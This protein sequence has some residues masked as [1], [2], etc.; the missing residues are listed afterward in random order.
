MPATPFVRRATLVFLVLVPT[1]GRSQPAPLA[2]TSPPPLLA[3]A[4]PPPLLAPAPDPV[5]TQL[6]SPVALLPEEFGE[7]PLARP[8]PAENPPPRDPSALLAGGPFGGFDPRTLAQFRADY[9]ATWFATEGVSGQSAHLGYVEQDLSLSVPL[10]HESGDILAVSLR[11][12]NETFSTDAVLPASNRRFPEDL[13]AISFG[14]TFAHTFDNGWIAGAGVSL[15]SPSDEP[16]HSIR[17]VA[18]GAN[19]FLRIPVGERDAWLF[20]IAY[21]PTSEV[22]FPIPTVAYILNPSDDLRV[23]IG[24][25]FQVMYRPVPEVQLDFSYMLLR[26]VHA[27]A[28]YRLCEP[29]RLHVGFDWGNES[30]F[31]ADRTD[32]NDRLFYYDKRVSAGVQYIVTPNFSLDMLGGYDFDRFWFEGAQYSDHLTNEIA[33]GN[34]AFLS[35]QGRLRW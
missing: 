34:G 32:R 7:A 13:W 26:T 21:S 19:A 1:V 22:N 2:P 6:G 18:L 35:L 30:Y 23:N 9:R 4:S 28:T 5:P 29:I 3:P 16:F 33:V 17:E 20:G 12:R 10:Y 15:G 31:L 27:R 11:A 14:G 24:L 8:A 25:P